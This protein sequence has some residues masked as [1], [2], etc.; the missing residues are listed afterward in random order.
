MLRLLYASIIV[1]FS[2]AVSAF[3]GPAL[4]DDMDACRDRQT[5]AKARLDACEQVIV[6]GQVSG[7]D[8]AIA[9]GVRGQGF[10]LKRNYDKA[11]AAFEA[12]H[13]ADPDNPNY[14]N[15]RGLAYEGKGDDAHAM[16]DYNLVLQMRPRRIIDRPTDHRCLRVGTFSFIILATCGTGEAR[17]QGFKAATAKRARERNRRSTVV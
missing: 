5:E 14:F 11:I 2:I 13:A 4:A 3:A 16:A 17:G 10:Q 1:L 12:A 9:Y 8:L 6:A 15:G 7:K